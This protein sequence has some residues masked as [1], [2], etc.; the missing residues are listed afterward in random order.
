MQRNV[1]EVTNPTVTIDP[2]EKEKQAMEML[3]EA[4]NSADY[5]SDANSRNL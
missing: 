3:S 5:V 4:M 1:L 2:L